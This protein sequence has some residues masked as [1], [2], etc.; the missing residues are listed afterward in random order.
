MDD[1]S[2]S[3]TIRVGGREIEVHMPRLPIRRDIITLIDQDLDHIYLSQHNTPDASARVLDF[4]EGRCAGTISS[5]QSRGRGRHL[6]T[7]LW[8]DGRSTALA[9]TRTGLADFM[10]ETEPV[11]M[12]PMGID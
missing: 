10:A 6:A 8:P 9:F 3:A 5:I 12:Q 7:F 1:T 4:I 11:N 2:I